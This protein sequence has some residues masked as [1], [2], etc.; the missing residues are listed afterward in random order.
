MAVISVVMIVLLA[1]EPILNWWFVWGD[2]VGHRMVGNAM[3][4]KW[5]YRP[6][7]ECEKCFAGQLALWGYFFSHIK[8]NSPLDWQERGWFSFPGYSLFHHML[9]VAF[10]I[11]TSVIISYY[12][13]HITQQ[14]DDN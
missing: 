11:L 13:N 1:K 7:W 10:A 8:G 3:K 12:I 2:R 9:T 5:F 14:R 6:I 4:A